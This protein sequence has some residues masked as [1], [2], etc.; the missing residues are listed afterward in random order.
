MLNMSVIWS[1]ILLGW[2]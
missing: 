1:F 2:Q